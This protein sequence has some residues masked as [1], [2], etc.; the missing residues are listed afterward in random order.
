MDFNF[1]IARSTT[2]TVDNQQ[3]VIIFITIR[4][5][6]LFTTIRRKLNGKIIFLL[7]SRV[8]FVNTRS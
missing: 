4:P 6:V 5:F 2:Y 3:D 8:N 7:N 1:K